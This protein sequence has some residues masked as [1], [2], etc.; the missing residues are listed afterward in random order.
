MF[1]VEIYFVA[2]SALVTSPVPFTTVSAAW[3]LLLAVVKRQ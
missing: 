1:E 3:T 2:S